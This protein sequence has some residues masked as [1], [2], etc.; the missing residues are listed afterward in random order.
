MYSALKR[1][2]IPLYELAREGKT[3][4]REER[5]IEIYSLERRSLDLPYLTFETRVSKGTYIRSLG[6]EI[7]DSL[8][9][10]GHLIALKRVSIGSF[11]LKDAH[12]TEDVTEEDARTIEEILSFMDRRIVDE[13][14]E[15]KIR[16]GMRL[17]LNGKTPLLMMNRKEQALAVYE[18][19]ADGFFYCKRGLWK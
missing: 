14:T 18:K 3:I 16:N 9:T 13:A 4:A 1:N 10:C 17:S 15:K 2:G 7:A 8:S 12:A 19:K 11:L 5:E 6:E